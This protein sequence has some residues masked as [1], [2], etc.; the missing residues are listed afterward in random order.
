[1]KRT[2]SQHSGLTQ[3]SEYVPTPTEVET[4]KSVVN[5]S[6]TISTSSLNGVKST[7]IETLTTRSQRYDISKKNYESNYLKLSNIIQE[8]FLEI[9]HQ[10][11]ENVKRISIVIFLLTD[12]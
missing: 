9:K 5:K 2:N 7:D 6:S 8:S 3:R 12:A 4:I 1:M 11:K 10:T